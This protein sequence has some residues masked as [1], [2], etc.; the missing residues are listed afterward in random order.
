[1]AQADHAVKLIE[2][3]ATC[4]ERAS[5]EDDGS[6]REVYWQREAQTQATLAVAVALLAVHE[7]IQAAT[8]RLA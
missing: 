8:R 1:M 6:A 7:A 5:E 2:Q 3:A 4:S